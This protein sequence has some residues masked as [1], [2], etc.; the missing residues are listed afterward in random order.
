M[1]IRDDARDGYYATS[2]HVSEP[3]AATLKATR[4]STTYLDG[5]VGEYDC[6]VPAAAAGDLVLVAFLPVVAGAAAPTIAPWALPTAAQSAQTSGKPAGATGAAVLPADKSPLR[7][8]VLPDFR[9]ALL[10]TGAADVT[11]YA[12]KV[13]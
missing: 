5:V 6:F 4:G 13:L 8:P 7:I 9:T 12:S 3:Y 1:P 11:M 10:Y 2:S